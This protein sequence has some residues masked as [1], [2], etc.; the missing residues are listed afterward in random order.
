MNICPYLIVPK[1]IPQPTWGGDYIANYKGI[2]NPKILSMKIG[3]SYELFS[4][5]MLSTVTDPRDLPI[6]IGD[7]KTGKTVDVIGDTSTMFSLQSLI[8]QDPE[9]VLGKAYLEKY[10]PKMQILIKFTQA[11]G[12]SFQ[13]HVRPG[14]QLGHW[15]PKPESWYY[16]EQGR[17]T[18]GLKDPTPKRLTEYRQICLEIQARVKGL[19]ERVKNKEISH[20]D[21]QYE[22]ASFIQEHSP[23]DYVNMIDV[24]KGSV[25]DLSNGG[26]HHSW[27]EGADI[28]L[29]NIL[30]EVQVDVMDDDCTLR[31]FDKGKMAEDG[32]IRPIHIDDYFSALDSDPQRNETESGI[33]QISGSTIFSTPFYR[34]QLNVAEHSIDTIYKEDS[35]IHRFFSMDSVQRGWSIFI[36]S[37]MKGV[38]AKV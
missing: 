18:L 16:F 9:A 14:Q 12:N 34:S 38:Y 27:E 1:L 19:G 3:Q 5:T 25:I 29:G 2:T 35:F 13:V 6:E 23:Y 8:D 36:P 37:P 33:S 11:K 17:A 28:P 26:I 20:E 7:P 21:A 24:P 22:I 30:Y 31:S 32:S 10:G 4:G 15:K